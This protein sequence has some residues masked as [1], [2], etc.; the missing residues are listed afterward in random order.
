MPLIRQ[1]WLLVIGTVLAGVVGSAFVTLGA[2]RG[3]LETALRL[4]NSDNAQALALTLSQQRADPTMAELLISAQ[5]DTGFYERIRLTAPDGRVLVDR[6]APPVATSAPA[7]FVRAVPI[8]SEPGIAQVSD[9]WKPVGTLEVVSASSF[10][11]AD[12]WRGSL[13]SAGWL[14]LI[15]ALSGVLGSLVVRRIRAPLQATVA[16]AQALV[17]RRFVTVSEPRVPELRQLSAAMNAMVHRLQAVFGEQGAQLE[18]LRVQAQVDPLTG[19]ADRGHFIARLASLLARDDSR[20][21]GALMLVRVRDLAQLNRDH[22]HAAVDEVLRALAQALHGAAAGQVDA[23]AGRLNGSDLA[24]LTPGTEPELPQRAAAVFEQLRKVAGRLSGMNIA[25]GAVTWR[26]G[27]S[28]ASLMRT[29]DAALAQAESIESPASEGQAL[30][31]APPRAEQP[32]TAMGEADWRRRIAAALQAG[33]VQLGGYPVL[34]ADGKLLHLECPLRLQ[35]DPQGPFEPAA[36]WLPWALR[37]Q[38]ITQTDLA[39]TQLALEQIRRDGCARG[40]NIAAASLMTSG[41][42]VE[43]RELLQAQPVAAG[44][45]LLEVGERAALDHLPLVGEL[46]RQCRP[47]GVK[48]GLE[49]AGERVSRIDRLYEASLDFVKLDKSL[50]LGVADD[51]KRAE[52]LRGLVWMLHGLGVQVIAEGVQGAADA[53]VLWQCGVDGQ[54]GPWTSTLYQT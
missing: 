37:S 32:S 1:L 24:L 5:F 20:S 22:G 54:T 27:E 28:V 2:A 15:G 4:K 10:A 52:F 3:Y 48:V 53:R 46:S 47:L 35:L 30:Y 43:L 11:H 29:A 44:Q 51:A 26:A 25:M 8:A 17:E 16:Q 45:L 13:R 50:S 49:H 18:A 14:M 12:L 23:L 34:A 31:V 21:A 33:S 39:A 6:G 9:G 7:W 42:I 36:R 40:V 19:V 38:L 41:F